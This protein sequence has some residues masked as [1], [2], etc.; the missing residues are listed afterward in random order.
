[1]IDQTLRHLTQ[2]LF[3]GFVLVLSSLTSSSAQQSVADMVLNGC[4]KE[5]VDYCSKVKPGQGR[6]VACLYAY[7]DKL[8]DQCSLAVEIG[9]VQLRIILSAVSHVLE[10]CQNDLDTHCADVEIGSGKMYQCMSKNRAKLQKKCKATF[11]KAEK[12]LK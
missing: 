5:L 10:Q 7:N 2:I 11:L 12:D 9:V 1:M 4:K 3:L 8:S 6:I